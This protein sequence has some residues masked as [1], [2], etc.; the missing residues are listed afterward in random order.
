[1]HYGDIGPDDLEEHEKRM[2]ELYNATE[3]VKVLFDH[4][5][6]A[7]EFADNAA[8]PYTDL[9]VLHVAFNLMFNTGQFTRSCEKWEEKDSGNKN[10]GNFK[11]HFTKSHKRLR[12][13]KSTADN[14]GYGAANNAI[15]QEMAI[16]LAN[17]ANNT[18]AD[19]NIVASVSETNTRLVAE[20][21]AA[22][23]TLAV[24]VSDIVPLR[25]Q[26]TGMDSGGRGRGRG[27]FQKNLGGRG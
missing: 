9:Q 7:A 5:K 4:I 8:Q 25:L 14:A 19:C 21:A 18:A 20:I 6:D 12:K 26:L 1:M 2:N 15:M 11:L 10:W 17:L 24:A 3:A 27:S 16:H 23:S 22:N 13:S